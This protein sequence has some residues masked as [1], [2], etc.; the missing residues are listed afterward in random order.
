MQN[1]NAIDYTVVGVY[2]SVLLGL[3]IYLKKM[4]SASLEDYFLGGKKLPWWALGISGMAAW[5]DITGTMMIT[6]FLFMLGPRG[7]FVEF[8]G[9]AVLI[10]PVILLWTGKWHRRSGCI[11]VAEWME[12]RFG[13]GFGGQFARFVMAVAQFL[14]VIGLLAYM[15]KGVGIFL[16]VFL[17]FSPLVCSILL[18]AIA[19]IYTLASG[20]YGVVFTDVFQSGVV[21]ISVIGIV[22]LAMV[23]SFGVDLAAVAQQVTNNSQWLNAAPSWKTTMPE[24]YKVYESLLIFCGFYLIRNIFGGMGMGGEPVYF[25]AKNDRECGTLSFVRGTTIMFRWPLMLGFAILG[26]FLVRDFF[27]DQTQLIA[28]ADLIHQQ[29]P[30]IQEKQ[31]VTAISR[32]INHPADYPDLILQLKDILGQAWV[33]KLNLVSF[34]GNINPERVL[35]AVILFD[36]PVGFRGLILIALLAASMS[37]FDS[38]VNMSLGFFTRDIYQRHIRPN[39]SNKELVRISWLFGIVLIVLGFLLSYT[40]KNINDIWG[41]IIMGL[42][43]GLTVPLFLRFYWWRFNGQGFAAGMIAGLASAFIQRIYYP[44]MNEIW[45]FVMVLIVGGSGCLIGTLLTRQTDNNVLEHFYK[46]T[47]PFGLWRPLKNSLEPEQ[48]MITAEE[49]KNDLLA[50]PFAYGWQITLFLW[51]MLLMVRNWKGFAITF[52][53]FIVSLLGM[54]LLW[55]KKLPKAN[56][57]DDEIV[58]VD[59]S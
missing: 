47:R 9:G 43:G 37:T 24:G 32:I 7:L 44:D 2:L 45:Q 4:A 17:P 30:G 11:T 51:P 5:L 16:S 8:R 6:S 39:A 50:L 27:A 10:L 40:V 25:G 53:I 33:S 21:L 28:A 48:R 29:F 56:F 34:H 22:T 38:Q 49:H 42:M 58:E 19:T 12:Y 57:I 18:I 13:K 23:K 36:I 55:Y 3:G 1:L 52:T 14:A 46:T 35:P 41:W 26:L 54:F 31:W 59:N 15:I 20:F